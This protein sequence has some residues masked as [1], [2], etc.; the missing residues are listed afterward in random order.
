MNKRI[1]IIVSI[2]ILIAI[3]ILLLLKYCDQK[4]IN[5]GT[6]IVEIIEPFKT[7]LKPEFNVN[8]SPDDVR[9][10]LIQGTIFIVPNDLDSIKSLNP[11]DFVICIF[12]ED[13][14]IFKPANNDFEIQSI[15]EKK[16]K[17]ATSLVLDYS[18]SMF[19]PYQFQDYSSGAV[20]SIIPI[21]ELISAVQNF[22]SYYQH[23]DIAEI[24]K[25]GSTFDQ[26]S[27]FTD[28][29]SYLINFILNNN[30]NRGSTALYN[31]VYYAI[32]NLKTINQ[33][34]YIRAVIAFAD[35]QNNVL[36]KTDEDVINLANENKI[37]VFSVCFEST[38]GDCNALENISSL[39]G[40]INLISPDPLSLMDLY[41]RINYSIRNSYYIKFTYP[42][43]IFQKYK[44]RA[45]IKLRIVKDKIAVAEYIR[46]L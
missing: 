2:I 45:K 31:S 9:P 35:G 7:Q 37:P 29:K 30:D 20:N 38:E 5:G 46:Y 44:G 40:G 14:C 43:D 3:I 4:E 17:I 11:D 12:L 25:F 34:E 32:D 42:V 15:S 24:I 19:T 1:Y 23:K 27:G 28:D 41:N 26:S 21:N 8:L 10:G 13:S 36:G 33:D 22:F 16:D 6:P 39:T 18:G